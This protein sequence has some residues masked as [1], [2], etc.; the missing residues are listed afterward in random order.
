MEFL[1]MNSHLSPSPVPFPDSNEGISPGATATC[2]GRD[3]ART[4][5]EQS[6]A[7]LSRA[8]G[9]GSCTDL[10]ESRGKTTHGLGRCF[11]LEDPLVSGAS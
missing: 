7:C 1:E 5:A 4:S 11:W 10:A 9:T 8:L 6:S 2:Q 3:D